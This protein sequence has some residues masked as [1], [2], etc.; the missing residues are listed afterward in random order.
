MSI[1]Y[2]ALKK[3]EKTSG[4]EKADKSKK[5]YYKVYFFYI[6]IAAVGILLA[7]AFFNFISGSLR[8]GQKITPINIS[9]P[10]KQSPPPPVPSPIA[11]EAELQP[12]QSG[13]VGKQLAPQWIL[14]GIFF[15][16]NEG[17]ALINNQIVRQGDTISGA[18][19]VKISSNEAELSFADSVIKLTTGSR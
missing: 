14:N 8:P 3:V 18:T 13:V 16:E 5:P 9:P 4:A 11:P 1:I 15:S 6:L 17:Y 12:Q 7:N 10:P 19:V 2:D